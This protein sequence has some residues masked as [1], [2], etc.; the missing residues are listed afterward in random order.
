V[1]ENDD[2]AW[3]TGPEHG[4][5]VSHIRIID[6]RLRERA[7]AGDEVAQMLIAIRRE[8]PSEADLQFLRSERITRERAAWAWQIIRKYVPVISGVISSIALGVYWLVTHF[9][10]RQP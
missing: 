8:M 3:D 10:P 2:I 1:P 6:K 4:S 7:E 5:G 9:G